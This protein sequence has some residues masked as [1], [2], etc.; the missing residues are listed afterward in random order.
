MPLIPWDKG[1]FFLTVP[2]ALNVQVKQSQH[3]LPSKHPISTFSH[4]IRSL[5]NATLKWPRLFSPGR[6]GRPRGY[7]PTEKKE[8]ATTHAVYVPPSIAFLDAH[9]VRA[10]SHQRLHALAHLTFFFTCRTWSFTW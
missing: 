1:I 3:K 4:P 5:L 6:L 9:R 10:G 8:K 7:A 2:F